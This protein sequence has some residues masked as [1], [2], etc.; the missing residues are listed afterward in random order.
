MSCQVRA[1]PEPPSRPSLPLAQ[2]SETRNPRLC[3]TTECPMPS[4]SHEDE[5]LAK[6]G[7]ELFKELRRLYAV[8][9]A[10]GGTTV[11]L[12]NYRLPVRVLML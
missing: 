9:E 8:A 12:C 10:G 11:S 3:Q 2:D 4:Y 6:T 5:R 7:P 1:F